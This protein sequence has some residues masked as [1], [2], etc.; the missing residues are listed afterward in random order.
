MV[1]D[2]ALKRC[3]SRS[4]RVISCP[5]FLFSSAITFLDVSSPADAASS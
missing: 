4:R 3:S 5:S 2:I 1:A